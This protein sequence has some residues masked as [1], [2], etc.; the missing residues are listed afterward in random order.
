MT[1]VA[2]TVLIRQAILKLWGKQ[3]ELVFIHEWEVVPY[4]GSVQNDRIFTYSITRLKRQSR[5]SY[6]I[7]QILT[8]NGRTKACSSWSRPRCT[9]PY[10]NRNGRVTIP[11][12]TTMNRFEKI[13]EVLLDL[14]L[15][16][17]R[18][19][20][21]LYE[22]LRILSRRLQDKNVRMDSDR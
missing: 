13:P 1:I 12:A 16:F 21:K 9:R 10:L 22:I 17:G 14:A 3:Q 8:L 2:R 20:Y 11:S 6:S 5:T 18:R 15:I 7:W 4:F 19:W